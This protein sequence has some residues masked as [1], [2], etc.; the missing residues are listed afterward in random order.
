MSKIITLSF[1][2]LSIFCSGQTSTYYF[3]YDASGN[4]TRRFIEI[5]PV[6]ED[7]LT[8]VS[9]DLELLEIEASE[10]ISEDS[11]VFRSKTSKEKEVAFETNALNSEVYPNPSNGLININTE[12]KGQLI[13]SDISGKIVLEQDLNGSTN[14]DLSNQDPGTYFLKITSISGA[15]ETWKITKL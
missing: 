13:I 14:I 3:E 11:L 2:L 12:L 1:V 9:E 8:E 6:S 5:E 4:R 7:V 10:Q 15:S